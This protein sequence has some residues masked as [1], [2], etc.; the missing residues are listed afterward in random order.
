MAEAAV[1]V[2]RVQVGTL[3][4]TQTLAWASSYYLPAVLGPA[5]ARDLG[6]DLPTVF[7]AFSLALVVSALVGP[8]AGRLID[9]RG[10]RGVLM[11]S[12]VVFALGL[13]TLSQAATG[14]HLFAAWILLGLGMGVG[15]YE[16]AFATLVRLQ[17]QG[18]RRSITSITLIAGFASTVGW[19]LS[20]WLDAQWGWREASLTWMA[21]HLLVGL[22]LNAL[23]PRAGAAPTVE[24]AP[25]QEVATQ[26]PATSGPKQQGLM[27]LLAGVF[28]VTAFISTAMAAHLPGV[29]AAAGASPAMAI[30]AAALL[31]PAQVIARVFEWAVLQRWHPVVA[32]RW[33]MACHPLGVVAML[34]F[35]GPWSLVFVVLHGAGNGIMTIAK[36]ALPLALFG[37]QGYG[38]RQGVLMVPARI[39]QAAAPWLFGWLLSYWGSNVM[40][41]SSALATAGALSLLLIRPAGQQR[42]SA[43]TETG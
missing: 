24:P 15:L 10:G 35:A 13:L 9:Q 2:S 23:L 30:A 38:A 14:W 36:G 20:A 37:S 40:W 6:L 12:N 29:I 39:A 28:A 8:Y 32:A 4:V 3:G 34:L 21:L 42:S 26:V 18:A 7:A 43:Q 41:V 5:I 22:P 27:V 19:P 1:P 25:D 31:G 16:A 11:A 33:A 17:G